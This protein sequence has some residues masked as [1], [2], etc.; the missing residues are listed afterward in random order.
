VIVSTE[1]PAVAEVAK[2]FGAEALFLRPPELAEPDTRMA[3]VIAH[4]FTHLPGE[5]YLIILQPTS[6]LRL[7]EDIDASIELFFSR[8]KDVVSVSPVRAPGGIF[9]LKRG[10]YPPAVRRVKQTRDD[11]SLFA[12][13]G[14]IYIV[15]K[16]RIERGAFLSKK[17]IGYIMPQER[18]VDIDTESDLRSAEIIAKR[19]GLDETFNQWERT[20]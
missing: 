3:D 2:S 6:P 11:A 15:Q 7:P 20:R 4:A 14:A 8:K 13:N 12:L 19:L 18:S 1:S 16:R 17:V 5:E 9:S 10:S